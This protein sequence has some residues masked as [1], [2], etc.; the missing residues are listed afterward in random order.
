V[1]ILWLG[2]PP[3][4][5]S[6]YG[7]QA[8]LFVPRLAAQGHELAVLCNWGLHGQMTVWNGVPC[9]PSDGLWGNRNLPTYADTLRA[10]QIISLCDAWILKPETWPEGLRLALWTPVDHYP[11]PP[12]VLKV[13]RDDRIR[14]VAMSRFG[15]RMMLDADLDP[16]YVPHGVDTSLFRP[17]P[18]LK[19]EVRDG[20]SLPRDAFVV[21][22]VAANTSSPMIPRKAFP[23]A[24]AAFTRFAEQ[25]PDAWLYLHTDFSPQGAG[26]DLNIVCDLVGCPPG[27]I[28]Y[29]DPAGFQ[30]G[31]PREAVALTYQAF[32]VLLQ[33]SMGEGFGLSSLEAQACGVPVIVSDHSAMPELLGAGWLVHGDPWLDYSQQSWFINPSIGSIVDALEH[34]YAE[35]GNAT[36]RDRAVEFAAG[37]DADLIADTFWRPVLDEL[38]G[39]GVA[40]SP[41]RETAAA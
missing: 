2:N 33:P 34:A 41:A 19:D 3:W 6:G 21:G 32:D 31:F 26:C 20:L 15:E 4:A 25:H 37:Y 23:Q 22:M 5:P 29:P 35:R 8:G 14:P 11:L 36:L 39:G 7:E 38:A 12:A 24:L 40:A 1:R 9:Y 10:D 13:L 30:L 16:L 18:E 27:R 28:R 17:R